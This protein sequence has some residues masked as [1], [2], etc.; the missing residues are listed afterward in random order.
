[1]TQDSLESVTIYDEQVPRKDPFGCLP[2]HRR[3]IQQFRS[4]KDA[5]RILKIGLHMKLWTNE[6]LSEICMAVVL[7][8]L[9]LKTNHRSSLWLTNENLTSVQKEVQEHLITVNKRISEEFSY[10]D[11]V[12]DREEIRSFLES[13]RLPGERDKKG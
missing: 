2:P 11:S 10:T 4:R 8:E 1:M 6:D 7:R 3:D 12:H 13:S 5:N 9:Y